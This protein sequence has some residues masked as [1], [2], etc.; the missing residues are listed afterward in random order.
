[1]SQD[2][3]LK[4]TLSTPEIAPDLIDYLSNLLFEA[5]AIGLEVDYAQGYLENHENLFGEIPETPNLRDLS[6]ETE[7]IA[8]YRDQVDLGPLKDLIAENLPDL[9][10]QLDQTWIQEEAWQ[11]NWMA[12]YKPEP[13][14]RYLT[15]VPQWMTDYQPKPLE[16]VIYLDPGLAFGTGNHPTTQLG[17]QALELVLRGGERVLDVGT[18]TGILAFIAKVLGAKEVYAYDLDPQAIEAAKQNLGLQKDQTDIHFGVNNLLVGVDHQADVI[19]ANILP[20]ILVLMLDDAA[21]LLRPGGH[22]ILG[23]V[24][25]D[26]ADELQ[27]QVLEK[28]W[29]LVS[30]TWYKGW[31]GFILDREDD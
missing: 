4:V 27:A 20:H 13:I 2:Q 16:Q 18:G 3:W 11:T 5:G 9:A 15:V 28:G 25:E 19:V 6:H 1:M 10:F 22:L 31:V 29:R 7:I 23:G 24:L 17:A 14:S 26:K 8:Y 30:R 12:H 21:K